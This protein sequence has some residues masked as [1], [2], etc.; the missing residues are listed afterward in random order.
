MMEN[1]TFVTE[2]TVTDP[3]SH[4]PVEVAIYKGA[5]GAMFGID[6]A[7]IVGLSEDDPVNCPFN[8]DLIMLQGD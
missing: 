1:A 4:M 5:N 8:G 2:V 7:F 6:S 3:D